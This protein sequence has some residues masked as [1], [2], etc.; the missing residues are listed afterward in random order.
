VFDPHRPY[1]FSH[2]LYRACDFREAAKG[3]NK[4]EAP[5]QIAGESRGTEGNPT[6]SPH[7]V[8][9]IPNCLRE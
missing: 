5:L 2:S 9:E 7:S 4:S 6:E 3:S 1:Q 8:L